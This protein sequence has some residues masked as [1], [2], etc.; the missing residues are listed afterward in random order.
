MK[1][2]VVSLQERWAQTTPKIFKNKK[3]YNRRVKHKN[4]GL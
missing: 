3:K 2:I 4:N 1:T